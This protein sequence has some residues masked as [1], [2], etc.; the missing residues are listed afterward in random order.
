MQPKEKKKKQESKLDVNKN[1]EKSVSESSGVHDINNITQK[2]DAKELVDTAIEPHKRIS[3]ELQYQ[4]FNSIP[5]KIAEIFEDIEHRLQLA[6]KMATLDGSNIKDSNYEFSLR[7]L[8]DEI[9]PLKDNVERIKKMILTMQKNIDSTYNELFVTQVENRKLASNE[10]ENVNILL[11][12]KLTTEIKK[13]SDETNNDRDTIKSELASFEA[14]FE[15]LKSDFENEVNETK[16][17]LETELGE[18]KSNLETE[19]GETKSGLETELG[20]LKTDL[21]T[22][23]NELKTN[24]ETEVSEGKSNLENEINEARSQLESLL[25]EAKKNFNNE[26]S[27]VR[28]KIEKKVDK[29]N[30]IIVDHI[31]DTQKITQKSLRTIANNL[32]KLMRKDKGFS[33]EQEDSIRTIEQLIYKKVNIK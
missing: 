6:N 4:L 29:G 7:F 3:H 18:T 11:T 26:I 2:D 30:E 23:I 9:E 16:T 31:N 10:V 14:K 13:I 5:T 21:E 15:E 1:D 25:G 24:L 12:D 27:G 8:T 33:K 17:N 19:L 28:T 32:L 22:E 20:E